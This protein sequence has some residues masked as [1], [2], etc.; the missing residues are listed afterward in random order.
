LVGY[1]RRAGQAL[2][3]KLVFVVTAVLVT[4]FFE[5]GKDPFFP[6]LVFIVFNGCNNLFGC[7]LFE[8]D[9]DF[10]MYFKLTE[11]G[12]LLQLLT[13]NANCSFKEGIESSKD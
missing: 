6:A 2:S 8:V 13:C 10:K 4:L 1:S 7:K 3:P 12:S 9:T 11:T 5:D